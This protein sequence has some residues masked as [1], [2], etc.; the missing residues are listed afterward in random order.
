MISLNRSTLYLIWKIKPAEFLIRE[1][2]LKSSTFP[3]IFMEGK[4]TINTVLGLYVI[5]LYII[6]KR[7][8][9]LFSLFLKY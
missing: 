8:F 6:V 1:E 9:P 5:S 2:I 7:K 3:V 4:K